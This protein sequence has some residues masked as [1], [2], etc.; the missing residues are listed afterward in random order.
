MSTDNKCIFCNNKC[1]VYDTPRHHR[2]NTYSC[3]YCGEYILPKI[4]LSVIYDIQDQSD[5]FKIACILNERRLKKLGGIALKNKTDME[6]SVCGYP[7]VSVD[8][9][10]DEFPKRASEFLNRTLLNL[11]LLTKSTQPF[12]LIRLDLANKGDCLHLFTSDK[13][14]CYAILRELAEQGYIRFNRVQAGEQLDVFCLTTKCWEKVENLRQTD[15]IHDS[16]NGGKTSMEWDVFICHASEDKENFVEPLANALREAGIKVWYDHFE[17][18]LGDSL[19][20]KIDEG[21]A[22][23]RYGV[24]VLSRYFFKKEWPKTELDALVSRQN[25]K[26]EKVILPIWHGI[27]IE[28]VRKFS[29]ILASKLAAQSSN[30]LESIVVQIEKVLNGNSTCEKPAENKR[31]STEIELNRCRATLRISHAY[32]RSCDAEVVVINRSVKPCHV[33]DIRLLSDAFDLDTIRASFNHEVAYGSGRGNELPL[34]LAANE[35]KPV[36]MRTTELTEQYKDTLPETV[37]L[38][39]YFDSLDKP[40]CKT[41]TRD[42]DRSVYKCS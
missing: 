35:S 42:K 21:L 12:K 20:G 3:D 10:L 6:K 23:S 14:G 11:S 38:C 17:F 34:R 25:E 32:Y 19:R 24:V 13:Q 15:E 33:T 41:L 40:L 26:G 39:V 37:E 7:M 31:E 30:S 22:N 8:D 1:D 18:K 16:S 9:I 2:L 28:E 5:K 29:P 4:G 27:G 36:Y